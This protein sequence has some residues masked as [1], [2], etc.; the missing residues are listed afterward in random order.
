MSHAESNPASA[1]SKLLTRSE[2]MAAIRFLMA[3]ER[4]SKKD[5]AK[6]IKRLQDMEDSATVY[7]VLLKE[8]QRAV[9]PRMLEV[10]AEL[11]MELGS[12]EDLKAPLWGMIQNP[13]VSDEV[14]DTANLILRQLGDESDPELY[15]NYLDDPLGLINRETERILKASA[16]NPEALIDFIDFIVSLPEEEQ[17]HLV[18]SLNRDYDA[19]YLTNIYIP[20]LDAKPSESLEPSLIKLLGQTRSERA[21]QYLQDRQ[22]REPE[23]S[24]LSK[25]L[26]RALNELKIAGAVKTL[27]RTALEIPPE[28][29]RQTKLYKSWQCSA[30]LPD[31]I[32]NQGLMLS[33]RRENGDM[34]LISVAINDLH[35]IIDCFGFYELTESDFDQLVAKFYETT[36]R[37]D[38]SFDY[39]L[40]VLA[41]AEAQNRKLN[42]RI[43]YEFTCWKL[44]WED[45]PAPEIGVVEACHAW[46]K[47]GYAPE[48]GFLYEHPDFRTWFLEPEDAPLVQTLFSQ[49]LPALQG[50]KIKVSSP[51]AL[52]PELENLAH[53]LTQALLQS[54]WR[55]ILGKR[56][57]HAAYLLHHQNVPTFCQMAA[58][59]SVA[60]LSTTPYQ[61]PI[62]ESCFIYRYAR[63]CI[64]EQLLAI[65][66]GADVHPATSQAIGYIITL[67]D[68]A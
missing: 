63:R 3:T 24:P 49:H 14:K 64:E 7:Q 8:L 5:R 33:Q 67:W 1:S 32:G 57:A 52:L 37:V 20:L 46:V 2:V 18:E 38:I 47:A 22:D 29:I 54:E 27:D 41:D 39:V 50:D 59:E 61:Q 13:G 12:L 43:P 48:S 9:Q 17:R 42:S 62:P 25:P 31:G 16:H 35:G 65:Q 4:P 26:T 21:W 15:L 6:H 11:L 56:L 36:S 23:D 60:L 10:V 68:Q 34:T 58:S 55:T 51:T 40:Q 44:L 66:H 30:T 53:L 28:A 19:E 45:F